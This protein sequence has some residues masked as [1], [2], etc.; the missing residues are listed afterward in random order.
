MKNVIKFSTLYLINFTHTLYIVFLF[1]ALFLTD[2]ETINPKVIIYSVI[3]SIIC[4]FILSTSNRFI[5]YRK[6]NRNAAICRFRQSKFNFKSKYRRYKEFTFM[7]NIFLKGKTSKEVVEIVKDDYLNMLEW[8]LNKYSEGIIVRTNVFIVHQLI[9]SGYGNHEEFKKFILE[10]KY[11]FID[12]FTMMKLS[13]F[14]KNLFILLFYKTSS[15][16]YKKAIN[17]LKLID[18]YEFIIRKDKNGN[19]ILKKLSESIYRN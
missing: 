13:D 14:L 19:I 2:V 12:K 17:H 8:G 1:L 9:K 4:A 10:K 6:T 16:N 15:K 18:K 7:P 3:S 5:L 11:L